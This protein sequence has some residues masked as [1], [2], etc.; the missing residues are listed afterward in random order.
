M[1]E[2][3]I[4]ISRDIETQKNQILFE[5]VLMDKKKSTVSEM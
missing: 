5:K 2:L 4:I 1:I 3:I